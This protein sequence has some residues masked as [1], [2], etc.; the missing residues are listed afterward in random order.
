MSNMNNLF[1]VATR[2]HYRF[3]WHGLIGVEDL[4]DLPQVELNHVYQQL[5]ETKRNSISDSLMDEGAEKAQSSEALDN[6]IEIVKFIFQ[7][8]EELKN[9]AARAQERAEKKRHILELMVKKQDDELAEKSV[10]EL[11]SMLE[12]L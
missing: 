7:Y 2:E 8:K 4:W 1:E 12:E 9:K 11:E 5:M 10:E 6:C 3:P